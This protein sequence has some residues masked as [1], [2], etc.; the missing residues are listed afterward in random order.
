MYAFL[1]FDTLAIVPFTIVMPAV[2]AEW[3]TRR[4]CR[5]KFVQQMGQN[6]PYNG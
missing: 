1:L 3:Y 4:I 6:Y 2:Y 5:L